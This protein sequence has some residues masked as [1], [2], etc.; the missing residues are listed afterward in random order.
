MMTTTGLFVFARIQPKPQHFQDAKSAICEILEPTREEPGCQQFS[1]HEGQG[2][3]CLYL[4][5]AWRSE[6]D[7]AS[8]YQQPYTKSVFERYENWLAQP[9]DV[10]RMSS[11]D[12]E[13]F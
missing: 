11:V 12:A 1:L 7:L 13:A 3:G 10:T 4:Y 5:E 8:H 2:D 6:G 9:V